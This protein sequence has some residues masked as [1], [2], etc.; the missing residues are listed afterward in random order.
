MHA[1][2]PLLDDPATHSAFTTACILAE[3][4]TTSM[5]LMGYLLQ[6]VHA[7]T[8][9]MGKDIPEA[10]RPIL[11]DWGA[12]TVEPDLPLAFVLPHQGRIRDSLARHGQE[13]VEEVG[14]QLGALLEHWAKME[15]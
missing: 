14:D 15:Q 9:A 12:K 10:A 4:S 7:F 13:D 5:K 3:Q 11:Q 6:G 8:W 2:I 1:L